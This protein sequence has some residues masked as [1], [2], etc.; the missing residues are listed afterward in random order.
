MKDKHKLNEFPYKLLRSTSYYERGDTESS[1]QPVVT[2]WYPSKAQDNRN[3]ITWTTSTFGLLVKDGHYMTAL[4]IT[5]N[6]QRSGD[7]WACLGEQRLY[8]VAARRRGIAN[9]YYTNVNLDQKSSQASFLL[10][11]LSERKKKSLLSVLEDKFP[12][13]KQDPPSTSVLKSS[14]SPSLACLM[15]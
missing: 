9:P 10:I 15:G 12:Q 11:L 1:Y 5:V 6:S 4:Q 3:G 7:Q 8:K 2:W 13:I 14:P